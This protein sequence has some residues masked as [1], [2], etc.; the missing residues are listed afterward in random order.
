MRL[1]H[2]SD[3][4]VGDTPWSRLEAAADAINALAPAVIVLS[5][6]LTQSGASREYAEAARFLALLDPPVIATPGNHDA[7]VRNGAERAVRPYRRFARLDLSMSWTSADPP[8]EITA[9]NTAR[10]IQARLDWS[11]GVYPRRGIPLDDTHAGWR[12]LAAHHP[13][14]TI[15]GAHV[16][17]DARRGARLWERLGRTSRTLLLCGHLH[18]FSV[19]RA[20]PEGRA[21]LIVAP[22]LCSGRARSA[23]LGFVEIG[24]GVDAI[25]L[26]L[27]LME[28]ERYVPALDLSFAA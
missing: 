28:A 25:D 27:H 26:R 8:V 21:R 20:P 24:L 14:I 11:Q 1:V 16:R 17:S 2:I 18:G 13:P 23:G 12:I 6:D 19:T 5:G 7:P 3:V 4:H 9:I 10:A 15:P 22:T